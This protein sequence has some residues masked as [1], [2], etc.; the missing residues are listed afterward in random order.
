LRH[1]H[2]D[3]ESVNHPRPFVPFHG[4]AGFFGKKSKHLD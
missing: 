2:D 3:S 1:W 4:P